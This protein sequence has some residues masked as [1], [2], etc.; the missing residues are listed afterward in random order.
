M[1]TPPWTIRGLQSALAARTVRPS[2]LAQLALARSNS[3]ATHNTYLWQ[4]PAW[5][6]AEAAR[7]EAAPRPFDSDGADGAAQ[8]WGLPISVKDCFDLA[9]APTTCGV[10]F[11]RDLHPWPTASPARIPSSAI[12]SNPAIPPR[13]PAA[14]PP[15][16]QPASLKVPR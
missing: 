16:Q 13:S 1:T 4:D 15:A 3:N 12:A 6:L 5:T 11:Y 8:F 2:E 7:A 10:K 9:G 14:H